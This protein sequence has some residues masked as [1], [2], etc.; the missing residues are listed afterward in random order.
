MIDGSD[1]QLTETSMARARVQTLLTLKSAK[2]E[3]EDIYR[4]FTCLKMP[5]SVNL[6]LYVVIYATVFLKRQILQSSLSFCITLIMHYLPKC[7]EFGVY[8]VGRREI[9]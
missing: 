4:Y 7:I 6:M 1:L 2:L 5:Y 9:I 8:E 3:A